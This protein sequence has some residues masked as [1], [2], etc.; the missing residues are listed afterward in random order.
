[1]NLPT[2]LVTGAGRGLGRGFVATLLQRPSTMVI[3]ALRDP[4]STNAESLAQLPKAKES[5]LII[6]KID[7][8]SD[9]D[10]FEAVTKLQNE[11]NINSIDVVIANA[12]AIGAP[13]APVSA[14]SVE[15]IRQDFQVNAVAPLL[16]FQATWPLLQK[17]KTPKF[18]GISTCLAT[19]GKM[20]EYPWPTASYGVSKAAMNY[21]VR[22]AHFENEELV[23]FAVHP[24]WY[25]LFSPQKCLQQVD[26]DRSRVQTD[27]GNSF[28]KAQGRDQA[29]DTIDDS[30]NW[31][32]E[33]VRLFVQSVLYI[34]NGC[35]Q[36]DAAT[37]D[38]I[39]GTFQ[40]YERGEYDW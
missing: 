26:G 5:K 40:F 29:P 9:S 6:V 30:V 34:A 10:P 39:S 18:V 3:A 22:K 1:M 32:L 14:A 16:L 20:D 12:A 37:K 15:G 13:P 7:S 24:G 4:S 33:K 36:V 27:A 21:F 38:H 23:A 28:A 11:H 8:T 35:T 25:V 2:Y 19:I 31:I 17:S